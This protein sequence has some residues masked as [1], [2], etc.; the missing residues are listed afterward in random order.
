[1]HAQENL[2]FFTRMYALQSSQRPSVI[3]CMLW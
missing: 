2:L 3:R 1:M